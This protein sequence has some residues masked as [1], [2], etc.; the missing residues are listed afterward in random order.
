MLQAHG[1]QVLPPASYASLQA[2]GPQALPPVSYA[3][4]QAR[5]PQVLPQV[6]CASLQARGL[7]AFWQPLHPG[8]TIPAS[9][10]Y[11]VG[12]ASAC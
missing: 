4:L 11:A 1:P 3:S 2:H 6:S 5:G 7:Q 10:W 9:W 8:R 12:W